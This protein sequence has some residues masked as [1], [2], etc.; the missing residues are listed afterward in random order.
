M[1]M[2]V[3]EQATRDAN[4]LHIGAV[5]VAVDLSEESM[6]ALRYAVPIARRFESE[7]HLLY[8][9]EGG[10]RI[11]TRSM[12]ELVQEM[13]ETRLPHRKGWRGPEGKSSPRI[14]PDYCHVVSG[15][16]YAEICS[17]A[18]LQGIDLIILST[19]GQTGLSRIALGST[20]ERVVQ[21][22]PCPVL[23][24]RQRSI[25]ADQPVNISG[26]Y[27][28]RKILVPVDFSTCS[29]AGVKYAAQMARAFNARLHLLHVLSPTNPVVMDRMVTT[30][31]M[32]ADKELRNNAQLEMQA[33]AKLD[34]L[35]G[36]GCETEIR[37]GYAIDEICSEIERADIDLAIT[38]THGQTGWKHILLGSVAEQIVRYAQC[39]VLVVPA[40]IEEATRRQTL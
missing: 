3:E 31:S 34:F 15:R 17:F 5:L 20:A 2:K 7:L 13:A 32:E 19:R 33:L 28:P 11:A 35:R 27:N 24:T 30:L 14:R 37:T 9:H 8:V 38:S 18:G 12:A 22:A 39:P 26:E 36:I 16:S 10:Q 23:V 29:L 6:R 25:R 40:R 21:F 4:S 1:D